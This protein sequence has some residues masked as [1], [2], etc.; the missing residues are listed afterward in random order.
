MAAK[1]SSLAH[2]LSALVPVLRKPMQNVI[3]SKRTLNELRRDIW[4]ARTE[5]WYR[6]VST[7]PE[8]VRAAKVEAKEVVQKLKNPGEISYKELAGAGIMGIQMFGCF[9][10]GEA[11]G[12]GNLTAYPVG[13]AHEY[14]D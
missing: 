2:K 6:K 12:R 10:L 11:W 7:Y 8:V 4:H 9:C 13:P 14:H 3:A 1:M 5:Y